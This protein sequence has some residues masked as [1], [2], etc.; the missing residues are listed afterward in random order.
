VSSRS[1]RLDGRILVSGEMRLLMHD[2]EK[3]LV[4]WIA[5]LSPWLAPLPSGYFVARASIEH[6]ALPLVMGIAVGVI[7]EFLG[8]ASVHTWLWLSDWNSSKR[9]S[10]PKAPT[11]LAAFLGGIYLCA[12]VGLTVVL[13]VAPHL[14]TYAPVLFPALAVVGA[15]NL[16][17]IA[18]Q[19]QRERVIQ[20]ERQE[21]RIARYSRNTVQQVSSVQ[22]GHPLTSSS[23]HDNGLKLANE[24]RLRRRTAHLDEIARILEKQPEI[25]VSDLAR[26]LGKSRTTVYKYLQELE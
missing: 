17:L 4:K 12:T 21:R 14:S 7:I 25:G 8:I 13:E 9:R 3:S 23:A 22:F 18:Q 1:I 26:R 11:G 19:E 10:D 20:A 6:L 2:H 5:K 24:A 16:A 15:V